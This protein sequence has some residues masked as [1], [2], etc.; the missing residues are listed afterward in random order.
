MIFNSNF[1]YWS[2]IYD[3]IIPVPLQEGLRRARIIKLLI[4]SSAS[5]YFPFKS[6][7]YIFFEKSNIFLARLLCFVPSVQFSLAIA[8]ELFACYCER[9]I[10]NPEKRIEERRMGRVY[11]YTRT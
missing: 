9:A 2:L 10:K 8:F 4:R 1:Y 7:I 5:T 11:V 3:D 6:F